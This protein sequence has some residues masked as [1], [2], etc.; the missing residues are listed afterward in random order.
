[1]F[2]SQ[3]FR[4]ASIVAGVCSSRTIAYFAPSQLPLLST[5]T[6]KEQIVVLLIASTRL[7]A[8]K[9]PRSRA[10]DANN[11]RRIAFIG[12]NMPSYAITFPSKAH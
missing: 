10:F 6:A 8:I 12:P 2:L 5:T 1:M 11:N 7:V 4:D 3:G 9:D